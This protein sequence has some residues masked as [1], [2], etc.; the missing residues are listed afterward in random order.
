M[1]D[2]WCAVAGNPARSRGVRTENLICTPTSGTANALDDRAGGGFFAADGS[3]T[4]LEAVPVRALI[5]LAAIVVVLALVGWISFRKGPEGPSVTIESERIRQDTKKVMDSSAQM[6][7]KA[8][9]KV[10][11]KANGEPSPVANNPNA[12]PATR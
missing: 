1:E 3:R 7:H 2:R 8:R 6:L 10:E 4:A 9:D 5:L 12:S 11:A